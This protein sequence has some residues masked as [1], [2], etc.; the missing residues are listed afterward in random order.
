MLDALLVHIMTDKLSEKFFD[1]EYG[2]FYRM[3]QEEKAK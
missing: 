1:S 3:E 2:I